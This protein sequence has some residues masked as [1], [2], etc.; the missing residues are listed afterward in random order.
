MK[1]I[2]EFDVFLKNTILGDNNWIRLFTNIEN[3]IIGN[4]I[5]IGFNSKIYN[6]EIGNNVQIA[7]K[8][9]KR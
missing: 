6:A 2:I 5:F 3:S 8:V 7:S 9:V 1:K 4:N